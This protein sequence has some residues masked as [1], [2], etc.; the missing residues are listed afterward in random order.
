MVALR[1]NALGRLEYDRGNH[2]ASEAWHRK[3]LALNRKL[4][5]DRHGTVGE[6]EMYLA[7]ALVAQGRASEALPL[8]EEALGIEREHSGEWSRESIFQAHA[9]A[10]VLGAAGR[11]EE[12]EALQRTVLAKAIEVLGAEH[13][14]VSDCWLSLGQLLLDKGARGEAEELLKLAVASRRERLPAAHPAIARAERALERCR[15]TTTLTPRPV[16]D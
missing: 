7:R 8:Q 9:M 2:A 14:V 5:G 1:W 13:S 16:P 4:W 11:T 12:A 6:S 3:A 10:N 15:A